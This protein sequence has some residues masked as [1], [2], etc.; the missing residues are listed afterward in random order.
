MLTRFNAPNLRFEQRPLDL[1]RVASECDLAVLNGNHGTTIA[2]LLEAS[3]GSVAHLPANALVAILG[4]VA[5]DVGVA[6]T[7]FGYLTGGWTPRQTV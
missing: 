6:G 1:K 7:V 5:G 2:M 3:V 4:A